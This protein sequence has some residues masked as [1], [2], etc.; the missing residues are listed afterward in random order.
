MPAKKPTLPARLVRAAE[1]QRVAPANVLARR[2]PS[3]ILPPRG[4][5]PRD[6]TQFSQDASW[7]EGAPIV[8]SSGLTVA[9]NDGGRVSAIRMTPPGRQAME[10]DTI[11]FSLEPLSESGEVRADLSIGC[12]LT[13]G[14]I[15]LTAGYVPIGLLCPHRIGA[16]EVATVVSASYGA[17]Y[18]FAYRLD[19]P[20]YIPSGMALNA[21]FHHRG[22]LN[23]SVRVNVTY[24]G[25]LTLHG[26]PKTVFAPW[27][28]A[29]VPAPIDLSG[30]EIEVSSDDS[31]LANAHDGNLN[32]TRFIGRNYLF[33]TSPASEALY[34]LSE[35]KDSK[36]DMQTYIRMDSSTGR[37]VARDFVLFRTMFPRETRAMDV[38]HVMGPGDFYSVDVRAGENAMEDMEGDTGYAVVP[39]VS[40]QGWREVS[41]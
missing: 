20:L 4:P 7:P 39:C 37:Q 16:Q 27:T 11:R 12:M 23:Q 33:F 25:R 22:L 24:E 21:S 10:L 36:A 9:A 40:I 31:D 8:L 15:P 18:S 38:Q 41:L 17:M 5:V 3:E 14:D 13:L 2:I 28:S 19:R 26:T 6:G 29:F 35:S 1:L 30:T 32:V 34:Y